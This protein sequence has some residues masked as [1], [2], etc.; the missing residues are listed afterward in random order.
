VPLYEYQ[1]EKCGH[2]SEFIEKP[3][4]KKQHKCERCGHSPIRKIIS[5]FS[6]GGSSNSDSKLAETCPGGTCPID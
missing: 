6:T 5:T 3:G 2:I 1:C 4:S